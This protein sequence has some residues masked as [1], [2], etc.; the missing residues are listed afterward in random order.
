MLK[1]S[2]SCLLTMLHWPIHVLRRKEK[3]ELIRH[4]ISFQEGLDLT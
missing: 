1:S 3:H 4:H 2:N